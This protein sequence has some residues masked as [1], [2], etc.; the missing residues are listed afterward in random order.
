MSKQQTE[1]PTGNPDGMPRILRVEKERPMMM[2]D[3]H[4]SMK[5]MKGAL[6]DVPVPEQA[7]TLLSIDGGTADLGWALLQQ[8]AQQTSISRMGTLKNLGH[9][10][11]PCEEAAALILK[12]CQPHHP[13]VVIIEM[14]ADRYFGRDNSATLCRLFQQACRLGV[15]FS[16]V[17]L[18]E[19]VDAFQ[20][21]ARKLGGKE[22]MMN[23]AQK[24][25]I[26]SSVFSHWQQQT[27]NHERDAALMGHW[28]LHIL[29]HNRKPMWV[30]GY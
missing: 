22:A 1:L 9:D 3:R 27:N 8:R 12:L 20:W 6:M 21:Q 26:F 24:L 10:A 28:W 5:V 14:P 18:P 4:P 16:S 13:S 23:D 15:G 25:Q 17:P 7:F 11:A 30:Y 2:V 19:Y 29:T